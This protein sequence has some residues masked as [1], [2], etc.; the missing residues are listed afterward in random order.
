MM[1]PCPATTLTLDDVYEGIELPPATFATNA[2]W[3]EITVLFAGDGGLAAETEA[4]SDSADSAANVSSRRVFV[5]ALVATSLPA[6]IRRVVHAQRQRRDDRND[7]ASG[8][9]NTRR[10]D[11]DHEYAQRWCRARRDSAVASVAAGN[12]ALGTASRRRDV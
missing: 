12:A 10:T 3:D 5:V 7:V 11:R 1:L 6:Q 8:I 2:D 4:S 9:W